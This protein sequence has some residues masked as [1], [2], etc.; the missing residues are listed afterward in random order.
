MVSF[1]TP[2]QVAPPLSPCQYLMHGGDCGSS[3]CRSGGGPTHCLSR[4]EGMFS[5]LVGVGVGV[6]GVPPPGPL[7]PRPVP[8]SAAASP[9]GACLMTCEALGANSAAVGGA[10][11]AALSSN[12]SSTASTAIVTARF[13]RPDVRPG[14]R[15]RLRAGEVIEA[16]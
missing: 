6:G 12:G 10:E 16:P 1:V 11:V 7:P 3:I 8:F 13:T 15:N 4:F 9:G 5:V 2:G 14:R